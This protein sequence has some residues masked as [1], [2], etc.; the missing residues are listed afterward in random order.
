MV[1]QTCGAYNGCK[2]TLTRT[3]EYPVGPIVMVT[4]TGTIES[5]AARPAGLSLVNGV[6]RSCAE[7]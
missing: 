7:T 2:L 1:A 3:I 6:R 5:Q 4:I